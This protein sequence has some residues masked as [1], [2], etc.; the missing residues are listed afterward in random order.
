M[1]RIDVLLASTAG[2]ITDFADDFRDGLSPL[3]MH[4][5]WWAATVIAMLEGGGL[6]EGEP[7]NFPLFVAVVAAN[8]ASR[9]SAETA[10]E[11]AVK[12]HRALRLAV[13]SIF[14]GCAPGNPPESPVRARVNAHFAASIDRAPVEAAALP[15]E[16]ANAVAIVAGWR[17]RPAP[18]IST[19]ELDR[20][21]LIAWAYI[22]AFAP[23]GLH[24][25]F[26]NGLMSSG[27]ALQIAAT[28]QMLMYGGGSW[29][30]DNWD[31][32]DRKAWPGRNIRD[33]WRGLIEE[34][35]SREMQT[36][37]DILEF[38]DVII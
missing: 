21:S 20:Q 37:R 8:T 28:A 9:Y 15:T 22:G 7:I 27:D 38:P 13:E 14:A 32:A 19:V 36:T 16:V 35:T 3:F 33:S 30:T 25:A 34:M 31:I 24:L 2:E 4:P 11:S 17:G 23:S 10:S 5:F 29:S 6:S 26:C 1:S 12:I 18:P